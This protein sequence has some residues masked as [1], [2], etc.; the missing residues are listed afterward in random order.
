MRRKEMKSGL[1]NS[2]LALALAFLISVQWVMPFGEQ[3]KAFALLPDFN[4]GAA[5][6]WSGN[7]N[8]VSTAKNMVNH[9]VE[10]GVGLGDYAYNTGSSAVNSWWNNVMTPLHGKFKGSLGNHDTGDKATYA[11]LFGQ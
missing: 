5:G 11:S 7:S 9:Q 3:H 4:F 8:A 2:T 6:D 10:L 1:L